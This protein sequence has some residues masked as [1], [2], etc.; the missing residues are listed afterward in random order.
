MKLVAHSFIN[1]SGLH[2]NGTRQIDLTGE[3][4]FL[5]KAYSQLNIDYPKFHKM[6][7]LSKLAFLAAE[8]LN[9]VVVF[10]VEGEGMQLIF[11]NQSS[12]KQTD[13]RFIDSYTNQGS[14]SPSLFVYTL[15]NIVTG[16]LCI[17]HKWYGENT[18][19]IQP[20]FQ[21]AQF[22]EQVE[23]AFSKGNTVCLCAWVDAKWQGNEEC[24]LFLIDHSEGLLKPAELLEIYKSYMHE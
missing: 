10:P 11:A 20:A 18:F 22:I 2:V 3:E 7:N 15:P 19:F 9:E 17:R 16:E 14:P 13:M 24:F 6:D 21:P 5:K 8:L 23:L 1:A 12:S 4:N